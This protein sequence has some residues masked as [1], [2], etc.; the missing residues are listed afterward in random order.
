[1]KRKE[2]ERK[3]VEIQF[4]GRVLAEQVQVLG[5]DP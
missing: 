4:S 5:F 3:H 2:R 1:M